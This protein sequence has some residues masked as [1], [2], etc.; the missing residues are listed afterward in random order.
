MKLY[1]YDIELTRWVKFFSIFED[2]MDESK[3]SKLQVLIDRN[4][5]EVKEQEQKVARYLLEHE[6]EILKL[7]VG[8]IAEGA[9]VSK[10]TVVRF[11][12]SLGFSG[13][14]EFKIF[15]QSGGNSVEEVPELDW[16]SED[17]QIT[18]L[19]LSHSVKSLE[20]SLF[21]TNAKEFTQVANIL[22]KSRNTTV[23]GIGGSKIVAQYFYA[24]LSRLGK[25]ITV[26]SDHFEL[27]Q[28]QHS[29][30]K[31]DVIFCISCSGETQDPLTFVS[32]GKR[33]GA[34]IITLTNSPDS[35]IARLS[36]VV[37]RATPETSFMGEMD[38][39]SR[40]SQF[41]IINALFIMIAVR[42][43]RDEKFREEFDRFSSYRNISSGA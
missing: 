13:L 34:S 19:L 21:N 11:C 36:D 29:F 37:L 22:L 1:N 23:V 39:L 18:E 5:V 42:C 9:N 20:G 33:D 12:K 10:A 40:L 7:A 30:E 15:Y 8:E 32:K 28:L 4:I 6:A 27:C 38:V 3:V 2:D 25:R 41:S 31:G 43:G 35:S 17:A 16:E 26:L 24:E 14:K